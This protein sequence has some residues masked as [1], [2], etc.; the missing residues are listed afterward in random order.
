LILAKLWQV[1]IFGH[2]KRW[3]KET[4]RPPHPLSELILTVQHIRLHDMHDDQAMLIASM[5]SQINSR[6]PRIFFRFWRTMRLT[7]GGQ[8]KI[9]LTRSLAK[10]QKSF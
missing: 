4:R 3:V 9:P 10:Y 5:R 8:P 7:S 2:L 1:T 6:L